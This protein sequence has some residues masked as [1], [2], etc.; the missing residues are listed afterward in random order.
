MIYILFFIGFY[1]LIKAAH[2]LVEGAVWVASHFKISSMVIG[3]VIVGIG[4]SIPEFSIAFLANL[5]KSKSDIALG[6]IVGSNTFNILFILG[7]A[8]AVRPISFLAEWIEEDL[9]WNVFAVLIFVLLAFFS[10]TAGADTVIGRMDGALLLTAFAAWLFYVLYFASNEDNAKQHVSRFLTFPIALG[11]MVAGLA[12]VLLGAKWVI[13]GAAA[14]AALIGMSE[15]FIGLTVIG[16]GT[17]L[18]ELVVAVT[19]ASRGE[20][21]IAV[22]S[23]IGSNIFDFLMIVGLSAMVRPIVFEPA[24]YRDAIITLAATLM[25]L[26]FMYVGTRNTLTRKK[27]I[28]FIAVYCFYVWTLIIRG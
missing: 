3:L 5:L 26:L 8:A 13:D 7:L 23:I 4:T 9:V 16:M 22:G 12:G 21:G 20:T 11:M 1:I 10:I 15:A 25:L 24:L 6:T 19:A 14:F 2:W 18:P 28:L 17:S 27:G